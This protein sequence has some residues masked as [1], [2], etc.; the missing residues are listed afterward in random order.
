MVKSKTP[1]LRC[2]IQGKDLEQ[3]IFDL[4]LILQDVVL[5]MPWLEKVN[6]RIDWTSKKVIF[7]KKDNTGKSQATEKEEA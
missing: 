7:K 5:E 6:P 4:I 2:H 1:L 3:A